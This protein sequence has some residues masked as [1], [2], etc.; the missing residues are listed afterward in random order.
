MTDY[1]AVQ[2]IV[3]SYQFSE[4]ENHCLVPSISKTH[5]PGYADKSALKNKR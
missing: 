2:E 3:F 5:M 1:G 4:N